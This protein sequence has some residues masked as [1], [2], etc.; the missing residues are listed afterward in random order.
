MDRLFE[1]IRKRSAPG[2][3]LFDMAGNIVFTN[4]EATGMFPG[5][6]DISSIPREIRE[7][8]GSVKNSI[9]EAGAADVRPDCTVF[10]IDPDHLFSARA[11]TIGQ[12]ESG[13][14]SHVMILLEGISDKRAINLEEARTKYQLTNRELELVVLISDGLTNKE[15][16]ERLFISEHTVK[17]HIKHIMRKMDVCTR[18][19]VIAILR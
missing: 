3:L 1:L 18:S 4:S 8:Y 7:L 5:L 19:G 11:F 15:I 10:R 6:G 12:C 17:D 14:I 2:I 16:A 13:D 9:D